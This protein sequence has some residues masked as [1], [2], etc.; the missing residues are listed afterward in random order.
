MSA[1]GIRR[2]WRER[3]CVWGEKMYWKKKLEA[4]RAWKMLVH[5]PAMPSISRMTSDTLSPLSFSSLQKQLPTS[6]I[7]Y[8]AKYGPGCEASPVWPSFTNTCDLL[9]FG[10]GLNATNSQV[11]NKVILTTWLYHFFV[12]RWANKT[13]RAIQTKWECVPL[14]KNRLTLFKH[15]ELLDPNM[16]EIPTNVLKI[17][18]QQRGNYNFPIRIC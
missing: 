13:W 18:E 14:V 12:W 4:C 8:K 16:R 3:H 7:C 9:R 11:H 5:C 15:S 2:D 1:V 6:K 17:R 10:F